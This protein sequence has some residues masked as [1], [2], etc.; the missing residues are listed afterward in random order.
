LTPLAAPPAGSAG[1]LYVSTDGNI[2]FYTG[3]TWRQISL[4][5]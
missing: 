5:P 2:Y 3:G 1:D 4:V